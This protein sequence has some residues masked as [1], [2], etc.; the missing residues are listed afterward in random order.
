M[1]KGKWWVF[2][3]KIAGKTYYIVGR[4][5]DDSVP[6]GLLGIEFRGRYTDNKA[7]CLEEASRLN[8][9]LP[10]T[11]GWIP[12]SERLPEVGEVVAVTCVTKKGVRNW[13]RAFVDV[14]GFWHGSGSMSGVVAWMKIDA[15][16]D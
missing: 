6:P 1:G 11:G 8:A 14:A 10:G 4:A 2:R 16:E 5:V 3:N 12:V 7:A 15:Y 13:N 9:A